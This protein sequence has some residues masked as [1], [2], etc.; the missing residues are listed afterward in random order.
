MNWEGMKPEDPRPAKGLWAGGNYTNR[1]MDCGCW[2]MGD[3]RARQCAD[4][5]YKEV[6]KVRKDFVVSKSFL[7]LRKGVFLCV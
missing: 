7:P 2:F 6:E 3:K 1:C 5:A 4:C